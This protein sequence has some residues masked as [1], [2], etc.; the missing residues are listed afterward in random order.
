LGSRCWGTKKRQSRS[1]FSIFIC[2]CESDVC[3]RSGSASATADTAATNGLVS[4]GLV[5]EPD[6]GNLN[7]LTDLTATTVTATTATNPTATEPTAT[8][9]TATSLN[10]T[11]STGATDSTGVAE[12]TG[13]TDSSTGVTDSTGVAESTGVTDSSTGV[14]DS[15]VTDSTVTNHTM[16][17]GKAKGKKRQLDGNSG[18]STGLP[19]AKKY[20]YHITL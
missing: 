19:T 11:D 5:D 13:V 17:N 3:F 8:D 20:V 14:T 2:D 18:S 4:G 1:Q 10:V 6:M 16:T 12:S 7:D 9:P 15:T